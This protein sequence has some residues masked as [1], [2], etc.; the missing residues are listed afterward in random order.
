MPKTIVR[1]LDTRKSTGNCL[2]HAACNAID[3]VAI[4]DRQNMRDEPL[5][6][7]MP[8]PYLLTGLTVFMSHEPCLLCSMSLTHSRISH[9]FYIRSSPG[10]GGLGSLFSVHEDGGLNH[11]FE[12]W[13]W[14]GGDELGNGLD[15]KIDP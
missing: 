7:D 2:Y 8:V 1:A 14:R 4:L 6:P 15:V 11:K 9:L 3:A 13:K 10:S 5:L 12:V